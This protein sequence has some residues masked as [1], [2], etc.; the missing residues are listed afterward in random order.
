MGVSASST[1]KQLLRPH[2]SLLMST[3]S[4][5]SSCPSLFVFVA[6]KRCI[7]LKV[8]RNL[9]HFKIWIS[10][11]PDFGC[12][13]WRGVSSPNSCLT[14]AD[15]LPAASLHQVW[16]APF[17][18]GI[19][20]GKKR[21]DQ[22]AKYEVWPWPSLTRTYKMLYNAQS[23]FSWSKMLDLPIRGGQSLNQVTQMEG[24]LPVW[25]AGTPCPCRGVNAPLS[26]FPIQA[27][28]ALFTQPVPLCPLH[29]KHCKLCTLHSSNVLSTASV[30]CAYFCTLLMNC[31]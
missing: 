16:Q 27:S 30:K 1:E 8:Q 19:D 5:I 6:V 11:V 21:F 10:K 31:A 15:S 12:Q 13:E 7:S 4:P 3:T 25:L 23:D 17:K 26:L 9:W 24:L 29:I 22:Q 20:R 14:E 2:R 28:Y 18:K